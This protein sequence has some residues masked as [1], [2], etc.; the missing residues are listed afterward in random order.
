[1]TD[2]RSAAPTNEAL[3]IS[4][5]HS[6]MPPDDMPEA[7]AIRFHLRGDHDLIECEVSWAALEA[8]EGSP[9][10]SAADRLARF[11]QH[12]MGIEAAALRKMNDGSDSSRA[13]PLRIDVDDVLNA[14]SV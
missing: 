3:D 5:P 6:A 1:M 13:A 8:L 11:A 9:A 7:R 10:D 14:P 12:R 2:Q 4:K